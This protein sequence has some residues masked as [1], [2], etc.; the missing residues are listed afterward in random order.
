MGVSRTIFRLLRGAHTLGLRIIARPGTELAPSAA[1]QFEAALDLAPPDYFDNEMPMLPSK[2]GIGKCRLCG[3]QQ[4][5]TR[6]HIP[7]RSANNKGQYRI[8]A[9]D[10]WFERDT[11]SLRLANGLPGQGGV[12]GYTL[13]RTCNSLT[14]AR[15]GSE[16]LGWMVRAAKTLEQIPRTPQECDTDPSPFGVSFRFAGSG[17]DVG[18]SPGR[19]IR[20]V[21]SCMCSLS[22]PW[23]IAETH[24]ALREVVL[25][26]AT[27]SIAPHQVF[28]SF[29]WGPNSRLTG[30]Q[31]I[32]DATSGEWAWVMELSHPPL[33][34]CYVL[35]SNHEV[36]TGGVEITS[37][38]EEAVDDRYVF[39]VDDPVEVGFTWTPYP[40][41]FRSSAAIS[42]S[43][44][45]DGR[46]NS[47]G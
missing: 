6:E 47:F 20:Q 33:S 7:P 15:Y 40:W 31:L 4:A 25:D 44:D 42:G 10:D 9:L 17:T 41:D 36:Q 18:V 26:Q 32:A 16:F 8:H 22:G 45:G 3:D 43:E 12:W 29:C 2:P 21:L 39:D 46:G 28:L 19:F 5:L 37:F 35:A 13:C 11:S 24:P 34:L 38:A 23:D 30:P 14:G 1:E 27:R